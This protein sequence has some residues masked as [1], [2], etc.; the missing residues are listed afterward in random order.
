MSVTTSFC[1]PAAPKCYTKLAWAPEVNHLSWPKAGLGARRRLIFESIRKV[2]NEAEGMRSC[3]T[4]RPA[5]VTSLETQVSCPTLFAK[6]PFAIFFGNISVALWQNHEDDTTDLI[7]WDAGPRMILPLRFCW[8]LT[9]HVSIDM[10]LTVV[11]P[12]IKI[13]LGIALASSSFGEIGG[14]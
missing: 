13:K 8:A 4:Y 10:I 3:S 11:N 12:M 5:D 6:R 9:L 7:R 14:C 1:R 2:R